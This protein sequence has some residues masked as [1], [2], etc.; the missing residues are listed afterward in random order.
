MVKDIRIVSK[1]CVIFQQSLMQCLMMIYIFMCFCTILHGALVGD[2]PSAINNSVSF[3][4]HK[5]VIRF[6]YIIPN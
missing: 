1:V 6:L 2:F 3:G 5:R 4:D